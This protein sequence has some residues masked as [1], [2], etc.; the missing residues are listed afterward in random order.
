MCIVCFIIVYVFQV[1]LAV[2]KYKWIKK[3]KKNPCVTTEYSVY[4]RF[5]TAS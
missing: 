1:K 3:K 4:K 2:L 5:Y